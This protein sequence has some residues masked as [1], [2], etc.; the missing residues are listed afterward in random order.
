MASQAQVRVR[1]NQA[2][3]KPRAHGAELAG[4]IGLIPELK[5]G[6]YADGL[7][8]HDVQYL[9]CKLILKPNHF[10]SRESLLDFA[11][12]LRRPADRHRIGFSRQAFLDAPL[13]I[14]EVVFLDTPD[15]RLYKN[16][17][18]L[19]RR[20]LYENG[21]PVGDPE[22]VFKFRHPD[23]QA[24]AQMDVR[25]EI[26]GDYRIKFKAEVLPLKN[27][28]GGSR[29]LFSHNVQFPMSHVHEDDPT[30]LQTLFR[31]F[32]ALRTLSSSAGEKVE[33]VGETIIEEV[34]Q[35]V[36]ELDFG[37]G[38]SATAN[39]ALWRVRGDHRPLV[40][41]F[42]FQIKFKRRDDLKAKAVRRGEAFYLALQDAARDWLAL[43]QTKTG[44][45]YR[46]K[47]NPPQSHE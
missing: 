2:Q 38:V 5:Q 16:A 42:A 13:Q 20:I 18:I 21:F 7:P 26:F 31:V 15:S 43:G 35:D 14:R 4:P 6:K 44:V 37:K 11:K 34:L 28:L 12:V 9:E 1:A 36:G 19:R 8:L 25:P 17:F 32:P 46:L 41:E 29:L 39:V 45:V 30:A 47:G 33:L 24:A 10:V 40:G 3:I 23:M 27:E 22:V